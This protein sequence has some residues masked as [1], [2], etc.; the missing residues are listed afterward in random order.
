M[1]RK[2]RQFWK[3]VQAGLEKMAQFYPSYLDSG[4]EAVYLSDTM[5]KILRLQAEGL[6]KEKIAEELNMS[7]SNVKYHTQQIYRKLR[8]SNKAEAVREAGR[9][10][11]I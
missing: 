11:W 2:N 3:K 10:G 5:M 6:S 7:V 1:L 4:I 9:R 8:V